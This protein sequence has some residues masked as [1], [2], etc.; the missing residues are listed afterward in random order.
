MVISKEYVCW[1][2]V[3]IWLNIDFAHQLNVLISADGHALLADFGL[4]SLVDSSFSL[5]IN[6]PSAGTMRWMSPE[7]IENYG[8]AT[9]EGDVWAFGMTALVCFVVHCPVIRYNCSGSG[10]VHSGISV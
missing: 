10:A 5:S 6:A 1:L 4:S 2:D 9:A 3:P 8:T 7:V